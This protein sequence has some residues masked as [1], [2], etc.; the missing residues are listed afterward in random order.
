MINQSYLPS[1]R[2]I[3]RGAI[4]T[5]IVAII[6]VVQT[7][8]FRAFFHKAPLA[9]VNI[10]IDAGALV[11]KDS[12]S[13]GIPDWEEQLFGLDPNGDGA[14]NRQIIE[15]KKSALNTGQSSDSQSLNQTDSVARQLFAMSTALSQTGDAT[16]TSYQSAA[17]ALGNSVV[18]PKISNHYSLG[19]IKT[20]PTSITSL[21]AYYQ[22]VSAILAKSA[23][24]GANIDVVIN[25]LQSGDFSGLGQLTATKTEYQ[26]FAEKLRA[27]PSPVVLAAYHLD[28]MNGFYGIADSFDSLVQ[29]S[30]NGITSIAGL[31]SY[32]T[33]NIRL[34]N[35]LFEI[36]KYFLEYGILHS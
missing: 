3:L 28:M 13:N 16:D 5:L 11:G 15:Q 8:W 6:L 33:Y 34:Q 12:N 22:A 25:A 30:D 21:T 32:K 1:K 19:D 10:P 2:F 20:V 4:A 17:Q 14:A 7:S 35:A 23:I 26:Q 9:S 36:H 31:S 27:I 29:L 24:D 18:V